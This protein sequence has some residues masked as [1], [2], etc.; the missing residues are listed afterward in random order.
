MVVIII[1]KRRNA[2]SFKPKNI[3]YNIDFN[4]VKKLLLEKLNNETYKFY[5]MGSVLILESKDFVISVNDIGNVEVFCEEN[6]YKN[7]NYFYN[8]FVSSIEEIFQKQKS[9]FRVE[10]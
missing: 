1:F 3:F 5:D 2:Y 4:K 10:V 8:N 9:K 6:C 7:K